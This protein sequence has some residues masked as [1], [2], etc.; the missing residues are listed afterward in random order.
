[1]PWNN[2]L[3]D[4]NVRLMPINTLRTL[5]NH[6][7][8]YQLQIVKLFGRRTIRPHV[9][10]WKKALGNVLCA[11]I[12]TAI[13]FNG[14][15]PFKKGLK[16]P[17]IFFQRTALALDPVNTTTWSNIYLHLSIHHCFLSNPGSVPFPFI[18]LSNGL[19]DD[20]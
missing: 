7:G 9:K 18:T 15:D 12:W 19:F 8:I 11:Y 3:R 17:I 16:D 4:L 13:T 6:N 20:N 2:L 10:I 1:M 14:W 5:K